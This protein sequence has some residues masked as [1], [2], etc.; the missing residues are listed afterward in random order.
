[1]TTFTDEQLDRYARHILLTEM[2]LDGQEKLANSKVLIIGAGGLG[3]PAALYL[4]GAGIGTIGIVDNDTVDLSN[5]HRQIAH[6]TKDVNVSKVESAAEKM[7]AINPDV[8]I[9]T[10]KDF[11][12]SENIVEIIRG[13]DFVLDGTDNFSAKFLINDACVMENIPYSH[14]GI[15]RFTGQAMTVIPGKS[16]CFRCVFREP[17]PP[18]LIP[19]C[20]ETGVL[21][22]VVG[23]LG[24]IQ[25]TETLKHLTGVGEV[26][27][28]QLLSFEAKGMDFRKVRVKKDK[29]CPLCGEHPVIKTLVDSEQPLCEL[30]A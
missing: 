20:L 23:I 18:N 17:P 6:F 1:M 7:Q 25:A 28:N 27:A 3:S 30:K 11:V 9:I 16:A 8:E 24:T 2:D 22:P 14:G 19:T 15:L 29:N 21:G 26:L 12:T 13:Y 4:A 10:Y 5:I